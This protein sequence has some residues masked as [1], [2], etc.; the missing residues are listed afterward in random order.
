MLKNRITAPSSTIL[1]RAAL[2]VLIFAAF[3]LST[4]QSQAQESEHVI[5]PRIGIVNAFEASQFAYDSG[6]GWEL[7]YFHWNQLQPNGPADWNASGPTGDWLNSARAAGREA[8]GVLI[9]TPAW[10]TDGTPTTGVPEGLFLPVNDPGNTW[11]AFV[12]QAVGYYGARGVN[13]WVIWENPDIPRSGRGYRWEGTIEE[14]YQLVKVAYLVAQEANPNA[15]IHL[16]GIG[17]F[18]PTWFSRFLD[19]VVDDS[20][21]PANDYYFD[22]ATVHIFFSPDSV[23]TLAANPFY[24]MDSK[25]VPLKPVWIN[26]TNARPAV[27]PDVYPE[28][29][30][31]RD[32]SKVTVEQQAA[33]IIQAYALGFAAGVER[34][35]TYRLVDNLEEDS[36]QAFGLVRVDGSARPAYTAQQIVAE[37]FNG[38]IFA[39]R[40]DEEAHPLLEYVRLTF[41]Q[42]VTHVV[43]ARTEETATLVIPAR[44]EQATLID[45]HNNRWIVEP[46]IGEYRVVAAGADC[47]EPTALRG[48][49]IGGDPWL[50]VEDGLAD[51]LNEAPPSVQVEEGGVTPTP[52]PGMIMTA[53]ARAMP[54][55]TPTPLPT[56]TPTPTITPTPSPLP[57][58]TAT[59]EAPPTVESTAPPGE[60]PQEAAEQVTLEEAAEQPAGAGESANPPAGESASGA[61]PAAA[62][63]GGGLMAF[64]PLILIGA[65]VLVIAGGTAYY[66]RGLPAPVYPPDDG[67]EEPVDDWPEDEAADQDEGF[68]DEDETFYAD[69]D[70][71][72]EEDWQ[73]T[74][75]LNEGELPPG[76]EDDLE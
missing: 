19:V 42:K 35:A 72:S 40:V 76:D 68:Y 55:A 73:D 21:A 33:F 28:D 9:D 7:V 13:H 75:F 67:A 45:V 10:A 70:E 56:E 24:L 63:P 18:D 66:L 74:R 59:Q 8:V 50:L 71:P 12:R 48:C 38:F 44:S 39:R 62:V 15:V 49:L 34:I 2:L 51:P 41:P 22:I 32:Y 16:G 23:Y 27:D 20:T 6:A 61:V 37:E 43:W 14:Y 1:R 65:G 53:T 4:G 47:N 58:A 29:A 30:T 46:E 3:L 54:T 25:G 11:A 36:F 69:E 57:E 26:Q 64:L 52:D 31:F 60:T 5:N 17:T